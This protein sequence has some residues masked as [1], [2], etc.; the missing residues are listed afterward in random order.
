[1][2][3]TPEDEFNIAAEHN[4]RG[5]QLSE[6]G[7]FEGALA[8]FL[9]ALDHAPDTPL[10]LCNLG[11]TSI[12]LSKF[13]AAET[14]CRKALD[15]DPAFTA[16]AH[17]YGFALEAQGKHAECI[18]FCLDMLDANPG[19]ADLQTR[20]I[21]SLYLTGNFKDAIDREKDTAEKNPT[22][23]ILVGR[24]HGALEQ[25]GRAVEA[26]SPIVKDMPERLTYVLSFIGAIANC[27]DFESMDAAYR[28]LE[29]TMGPSWH[30]VWAYYQFA[31]HYACR[32]IMDVFEDDL[33]IPLS[34]PPG[35]YCPVTAGSSRLVYGLSELEAAA[36]NFA[37][38][39]VSRQRLTTGITSFME[40]AGDIIAG[41][42][43]DHHL[44]NLRAFRQ[45]SG[46]GA[47]DPV[48]VL[49]TG[50]CGTLGLHE[51]LSK[52]GQIMSFHTLHNQLLPT[53]RNHVLYRIIEGSLDKDTLSRI[54]GL[55]VESRMAEFLFAH[56]NGKTPVIINHWDTVFAPF[57]AVFFP[58]SVFL[59]LHR[60]D[61]KVFASIYGKNQWQNLQLQ[62]L[63]Y[64]ADFPDGR[65][66]Y[67]HDESLEIEQMIAWY[68]FVTREFIHAFAQTVTEDRVTSIRS[69]DLF[70][71]SREHFDILRR[72]F[73]IDDLGY[74]DFRDSYS[75]PVNP[76]SD[77]IQVE[78]DDIRRRAGLIPALLDRLERRGGFEP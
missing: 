63:R 23:R 1:M 9:E 77:S 26:L 33:E 59:H 39:R 16:A 66:I 24:A 21:N 12:N 71:R 50:R 20:I 40:M 6:S 34:P 11:F 47:N 17:F 65:F 67:A 35:P 74:E 42:Q 76:K 25:H 14:Y 69:E 29:K 61:T 45:P 15:L 55:Y 73:P 51:F 28:R 58:G 4:N 49:S 18:R 43:F 31:R 64:D 37:S 48:F 38:P 52:S 36:A 56:K 62:Y 60:D 22:E 41:G 44:E 68:L 54:L 78:E 75:A 30:K 3:S 57:N 10:I 72:V 46:D 53:D 2:S 27:G 13:T 32:D 7:D 19:D 5:S 70:A 8:C